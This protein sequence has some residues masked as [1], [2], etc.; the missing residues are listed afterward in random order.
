MSKV[1]CPEPGSQLTIGSIAFGPHRLES[2]AVKPDVVFIHPRPEVTVLEV[3]RAA[4]CS[5]GSFD[6]A[7]QD[8]YQ[9]QL[10]AALKGTP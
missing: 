10:D 6:R 7:L 5:L 2:T 4:I 3:A 1:V 9:R 8:H